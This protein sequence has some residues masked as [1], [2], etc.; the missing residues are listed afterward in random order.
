MLRWCDSSERHI[1]LRN[2]K[3]FNLK[4]FLIIEKD[5]QISL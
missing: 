5:I 2:D 1:G 3:D 4:K